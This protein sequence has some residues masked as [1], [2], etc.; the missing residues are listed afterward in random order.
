MCKRVYLT[1]KEAEMEMQELRNMEGFTD[2]ME[3]DYIS[4]M[5]KDAKRNSMIGDKLA[6]NEDEIVECLEYDFGLDMSWHPMS[7]N[8]GKDENND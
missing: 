3:T 6:F 5:I 4:R 2:K 8:Y 1:A 7:V